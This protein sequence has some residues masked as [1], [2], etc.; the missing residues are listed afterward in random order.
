[1]STKMFLVVTFENI[2]S[3]TKFYTFRILVDK[4]FLDSGCT[5]SLAAFRC[6]ID[7]DNSE[8]LNVDSHLHRVMLARLISLRFLL[9]H[10]R[11]SCFTSA[12]CSPRKNLW[13]S[14]IMG[15]HFR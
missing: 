8:S 4:N 3:F 12:S 11:R 15:F 5:W 1:M 9:S 13:F 10:G 7:V 2:N 6:S 14:T